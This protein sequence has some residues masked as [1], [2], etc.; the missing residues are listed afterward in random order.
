MKKK[1]LFI[2]GGILILAAAGIGVY[3]YIRKKKEKEGGLIEGSVTLID[4]APSTPSTPY[5]PST[6][7]SSNTVATSS[8]FES[9]NT[10]SFPIKKGQTSKLVY[11]LQSVLNYVY[12]A[13]LTPDGVFGSK[14]ETALNKATG[15]TQ[16]SNKQEAMLLVA[17]VEEKEMVTGSKNEEIRAM[18]NKLL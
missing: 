18:A 16:I 14:T 4:V 13:G 3:L 1:G 6:P 9:L 11:L 2:V 12:G 5:V 10:G 7:T 17:R 8:K 15:K